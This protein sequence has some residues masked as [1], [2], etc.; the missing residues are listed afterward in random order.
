ML[1]KYLAIAALL[2][3]IVAPVMTAASLAGSVKQADSSTWQ[4]IARINPKQPYTIRLTNQTAIA[5]EYAST[6]NEFPTRTVAPRATATLT[7]LPVP[8]Y[9]LI[10]S[11]DAEAKLKYT[12]SARQ[13]VITINVQPL[14]GDAAGNTTVNIQETGGIYA[15]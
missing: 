1:R 4:P 15:Y 12:V 11:T 13:N 8:I 6:S 2:F 7:K 10:S 14:M 3:P 5:I 9:L